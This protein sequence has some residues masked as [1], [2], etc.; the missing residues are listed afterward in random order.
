MEQIDNET[1]ELKRYGVAPGG[2]LLCCF[3]RTA[4]A[5]EQE[6]SSPLL[7]AQAASLPLRSSFSAS[8]VSCS[9][10]QMFTCSIEKTLA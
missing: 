2:K 9:H 8:P 6:I 10:D 1:F 7:N 5:E 3:I 4:S